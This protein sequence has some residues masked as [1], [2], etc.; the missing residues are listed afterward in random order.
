[1]TVASTMIMA[2]SVRETAKTFL[3]WQAANFLIWI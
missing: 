3:K 1:M 2:M